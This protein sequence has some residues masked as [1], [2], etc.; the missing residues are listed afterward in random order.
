M[1]LLQLCYRSELILPAPSW[2]SYAPQAAIIGRDVRYMKTRFEDQWRLTPTLLESTCRAALNRPRL[3]ILNYP[4]NPPGG[5]YSPEQ[6]DA[7]AEVARRR[8][9]LDRACGVAFR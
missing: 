5:T 3:L 9:E 2:V 7:L 1:F 4:N 8:I 6:L